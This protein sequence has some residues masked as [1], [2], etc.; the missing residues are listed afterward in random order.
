MAGD[1]SLVVGNGFSLSF[2]HFF[3]PKGFTNTQEP[4]SWNIL[5]PGKDSPL[6]DDLCNF[7]EFSLARTNESDFDV[8]KKIVDAHRAEAS[9]E[10]IK[11]AR[12][13]CRH[14]LTLAFS[15]YSQVQNKLL[16][17]SWSWYKWI[18]A[19]RY[20][21]LCASSFNYDLLLE[22]IFRK[23]RIQ[24]SDGTE[25][26]QNR[27]TIL[28]KPHG[29]CCYDMHP[30]IISVADR[31]Y[32]LKYYIDENDAPFISL[33]HA[34]LMT[35]RVMPLCVIPNGNNIYKT[36]H[37]MM[38]HNQRLNDKLRLSSYCVFIGISYMP[39]DR[40]EINNM[41]SNL[42]KDCLVIIAN[43]NP[44]NDFIKKVESFGLVYEKWQSFNGPV[45]ENG[46]LRLI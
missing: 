46:K 38:H 32:P 13:E 6:I 19:H 33:K 7:K 10:K 39:C 30:G 11:K 40:E 25:P 44:C 9:N 34:N 43:P 42:K 12:L 35:F 20:R 16:K 41:L 37:S 45:D 21:I 27:N 5:T 8:F 4:L 24:Y 18:S 15:R 2:N 3:N 1:I 26:M 29:S 17:D 31:T 23:L 22:N 14:Y 28:H 36:Y